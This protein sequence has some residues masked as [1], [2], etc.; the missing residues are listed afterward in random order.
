MTC[1]EEVFKTFLGE[2]TRRPLYLA[3][4]TLW[5]DW[6]KTRDTL[7]VDWQE[8]SL[9]KIS[10][11]L[12]S[13]AW[14]PIQV[15]DSELSSIDVKIVETADEKS[16]TYETSSRRLVARWIR[17]P[18][19]DWWQS[20]YP[21]RSEKD[22]EAGLELVESRTY[23]VDA[24]ALSQAVINV[25]ETG[26]VP[27]ELPK[28][29]Y[30][31]L[32]HDFLG[33][34]EGLMLLGE[35]EIQ[36]MITVLESKLQALTVEIAKLPGAIVL[37]PDNLDGQFVSPGAFDRY[38]A[39]SY[40]RTADI[41]H[42]HGKW[43]VSHVGG[44]AAR[45]LEGMASTGLDAIQGIC[46]PPQSDTPLPEARRIVGPGILLW[47]GIPQDIL[48]DTHSWEQFEETV[49]RVAAEARTS[50]HVILGVADRVPV[51]AALDRLQSISS[52]IHAGS[53]Q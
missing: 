22:L 50:Q 20:Q 16:I 46:E 24:S 15:W 44:P 51:G 32:L 3:D 39:G 5:Y 18:D 43:L 31:E 17:G 35:P 19:E 53:S 9:P 34:S 8:D 25:D 36:E 49:T 33:W 26:I 13:P 27:L 11:R 29:P 40:R 7:P 2:S 14:L 23:N 30:S 42:E 12:G 4:L 21:I 6:H 47:G 37:S 38:L 10:Q 48:L 41:L 28:R 1:R 45:L 52:L